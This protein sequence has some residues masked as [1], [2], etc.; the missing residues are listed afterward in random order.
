MLVITANCAVGRRRP[1][2]LLARG[3]AR[4]S[5]AVGGSVG[6]AGTDYAASAACPVLGMTAARDGEFRSR[7]LLPRGRLEL[8]D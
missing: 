6:A 3:H 2:L 1:C 4:G 5:P 7:S 8:H